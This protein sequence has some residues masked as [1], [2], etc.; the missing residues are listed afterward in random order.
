MKIHELRDE[1]GNVIH[2]CATASFP[3]PSDHWI[4][5]EPVEPEFFMELP[6]SEQANIEQKSHDALKY[7]IQVCTRSG[8]EDFD[9]DAI[10]MTFRNTLF[11]IGKSVVG[12]LVL[13]LFTAPCYAQDIYD[14]NYRGGYERFSSRYEVNPPKIYSGGKYLGELSADRYAPDSVSNMYGRYGSRYSPDSINNP[15]SPVGRY[16]GRPV[17]VYPRW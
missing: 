1:D 3:L 11:G 16:S 5:Q 15:Y 8:K 6:D 9:P 17:Y 14:Y 4:Y 7:T 13:L 12:L 10:L 2:A